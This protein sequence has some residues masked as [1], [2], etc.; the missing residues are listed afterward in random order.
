MMRRHI[1]SDHVFQHELLTKRHQWFSVDKS[2]RD[3]CRVMWNRQAAEQ[4]QTRN[5][6]LPSI[7][8]IEKSTSTDPNTKT[9]ENNQG[10]SN[11][12]IR[13]DFLSKQP[14]MLEI[15]YTPHASQFLKQKHHIAL[16]KE[17]AQRRHVN[18]QTAA[19]NDHRYH[20]L[21]HSLQDV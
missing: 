1:A 11:E 3:T 9:T 19:I 2:Y 8:P 16:R 20:K 13:H 6:V 21:V 18:L 7:Y 4:N 14:V 5:V 12:K 10:E 15:M 17:S